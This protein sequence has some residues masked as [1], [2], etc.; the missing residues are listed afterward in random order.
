MKFKTKYKSHLIIDYNENLFANRLNKLLNNISNNGNT[1]FD[2]KYS[3]VSEIGNVICYTAL[4][5]EE[6]TK[7]EEVPESG[8]KICKTSTK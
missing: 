5:I 2:L 7:V 1:V 4:I 8:V 3:A 6:I